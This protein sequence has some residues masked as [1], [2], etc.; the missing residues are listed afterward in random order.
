MLRIAAGMG[1]LELGVVSLD[2]TRIKANA[3]KHSALSYG[4]IKQLEVQIQAEIDELKRRA[5]AADDLSLPEE[6]QRREDRL[7]AIGK[8]KAEIE[9]RAAERDAPAKAEYEAKV[10]R[11]DAQRSAAKARSPE[12]GSRNRRRSGRSTR[13]R[14]TSPMPSHVSCRF[15]AGASNKA[16]TRKRRW[17]PPRC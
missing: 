6:L 8:A 14:S 1:V 2:G 12:A 4:R 5:E 3:S 16:T 15:P 17:T 10:E 9:A 11:R 7:A 13:I